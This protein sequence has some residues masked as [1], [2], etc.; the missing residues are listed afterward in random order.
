[1]S[2]EA[3][4]PVLPEG[5]AGVRV[6]TI[7]EAVDGAHVVRLA[8]YRFPDGSEAAYV[9]AHETHDGARP[10]RVACLSAVVHLLQNVGADEMWQIGNR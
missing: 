5:F 4:G 2:N 1:M 7:G 9:E 6:R 10:G 3:G 8:L